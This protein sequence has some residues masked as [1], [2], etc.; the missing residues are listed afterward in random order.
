MESL[1]GTGRTATRGRSRTAATG[2]YFGPMPDEVWGVMDRAWFDPPS[3]SSNY[4]RENAQVLALAASL[5]WITIVAPDGKSLSRSWHVTVAG[6]TA[7]RNK[8]LFA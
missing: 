4:A 3:I 1:D 2:G 6:L 8:E 7:Y 5:G